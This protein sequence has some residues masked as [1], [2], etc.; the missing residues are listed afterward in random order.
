MDIIEDVI[1]KRKKPIEYILAVV[2]AYF[3]NVE[4]II[5]GMNPDDHI[6]YANAIQYVENNLGYKMEASRLDPHGIYN[7]YEYFESVD[8]NLQTV[9]GLMNQDEYMK[10]HLYHMSAT[11]TIGLRGEKVNIKAQYDKFREISI[12]GDEKIF[13]FCK[14]FDKEKLYEITT[15]KKAN[16]FTIFMLNYLIKYYSNDRVKY[17]NLALI[18]EQQKNDVLGTTRIELKYAGIQGQIVNYSL[19]PLTESMKMSEIFKLIGVDTV[20]IDTTNSPQDLSLLSSQDF[21]VILLNKSSQSPLEFNLRGLIDPKYINENGLKISPLSGLTKKMLKKY[22]TINE[23]PITPIAPAAKVIVNPHMDKFI[24]L[25]TLNGD[26]WRILGT[27]ETDD[28]SAITG[29]KIIGLIKGLT[30]RA[31]NYNKYHEDKIVDV[32]YDRKYEMIANSFST[33]RES[34]ENVKKELLDILV[35]GFLKKIDS[36]NE[37]N[38]AQVAQSLDVRGALKKVLHRESAFEELITKLVKFE[39]LHTTL[40]RAMERRW[41]EEPIDMKIFHEYTVADRNK[42]L[43][44]T[45]IRVTKR[46]VDDL[47]RDNSWSDYDSSIKLQFMRKKFLI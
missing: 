19:V 41:S 11:Y 13:E 24:I 42:I 7:L 37:S 15:S 14:G 9:I 8:E 26:L 16:R 3:K 10:I 17:R 23:L 36:I 4:K 1:T 47:D 31:I 30:T 38:L 40:I 12:H 34:S 44:E 25:E 18:V 46:A 28:L 5:I 2:S 32:C 20:N 43:H 29:D 39:L 21:G 35:E 6:K 22:T 45:M 27:G 33:I